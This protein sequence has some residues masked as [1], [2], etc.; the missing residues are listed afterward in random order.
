MT[1]RITL[2]TTQY[3]I[4]EHAID[5]T[6]GQIV[7]FPDNVKGGA[8]QKVIQ[9]LFNK[10]LITRDGQDNYFVAAEGY[11]ALGRNLP[12]PATTHP[13]PKIEAAV[14]AAEANWAQEKKDAAKR[15]LK[16]GVEG[17]PR[18]RENSKQATV[19]QML[20]RPEGATINQI[21]EATGWQAHTVRGTFAG[22]FKKK[23][24]LNLTSDK[25][26][27]GDRVY[28][29]ALATNNK[30]G[31][32][33]RYRP[34]HT[35]QERDYFLAFF[36]GATAALKPAP[37]LKVGTVVA[38][39]FSASPVLGFLPVR[40]ARLDALKVPKPISATS[41]PLATDAVMISSS[42]SMDLPA[43]ALETSVLVA[44]ASISSDL[45]MVVSLPWLGKPAILPPIELPSKRA[46][47]RD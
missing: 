9:G 38:A 2:S 46:W 18:I 22:A 30:G 12:A 5:Q 45:F 27:G 40:A 4:L 17:K 28:R 3:D 34:C 42:A 26:E 8:R 31:P 36:F 43:A 37:A 11:V 19:I 29:L 10:A 1:T 23:L 20:Q 39:I 16:V 14:S 21:C 44:S 13:D 32:V 6:N 25:A 7:W 35:L 15:L 24:G 41:L 47:L 33:S